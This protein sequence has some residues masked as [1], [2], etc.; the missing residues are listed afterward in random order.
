ML[1]TEVGFRNSR[2]NLFSSNW[3]R[4][5]CFFSFPLDDGLSETKEKLDWFSL[6]NPFERNCYT[7]SF[8]KFLCEMSRSAYPACVHANFD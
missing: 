2:Y 4:R 3:H 6:N 5:L 1:P 7:E 8:I